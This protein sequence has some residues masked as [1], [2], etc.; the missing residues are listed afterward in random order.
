[1]AVR[2]GF[3]RFVHRCRPPVGSWR[4]PTD[5]TEDV[6]GLAVKR[7]RR[8]DNLAATQQLKTVD[9]RQALRRI[10]RSLN[11]RPR[12]TLGFMTPSESLPSFLR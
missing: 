1:M 10:S 11:K 7:P 2:A 8:Y 4:G 12:K 5:H 9:H 3:Q 6:E